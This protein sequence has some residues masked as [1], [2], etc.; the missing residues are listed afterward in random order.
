MRGFVTAWATDAI[1]GQSVRTG[2]VGSKPGGII[3]LPVNMIRCPA[4]WSF[5]GCVNDRQSDHR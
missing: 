3:V 2:R 4:E 1:E 5:D